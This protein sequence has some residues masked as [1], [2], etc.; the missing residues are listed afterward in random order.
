MR[1]LSKCVVVLPGKAY[2][3]KND[4]DV[5]GEYREIVP[6]TYNVLGMHARTFRVLVRLMRRWTDDLIEDAM[7][8][9]TA[10]IH[11]LTIAT[12]NVLDFESFGVP[13]FFAMKAG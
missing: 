8:A 9:A 13:T 3:S 6:E 10:A 4:C 2:S 1:I 7:I 12:R 11:R 5:V